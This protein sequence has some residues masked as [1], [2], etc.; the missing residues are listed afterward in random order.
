MNVQQNS[1][2]LL[3]YKFK[4]SRTPDVE[5]RAQTVSIPGLSLGSVD[6][7]TPFG[8]R[9][10][11]HGNIQYDDLTISFLVGEELKDYLEIHNWMNNLG[12]PDEN[13]NYPLDQYSTV[14]DISVLILNSAMN[15]IVNVRFTDAYPVSISS[16]DFDSTLT[17]VQYAQANVTFKYNRFYFDTI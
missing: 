13:Y 6:V 3:N 4:L 11:Y 1:L 10:P 16:I 5:Y 7:A 17:E 12:R 14:S 15:P 2:A 8:L 9:V